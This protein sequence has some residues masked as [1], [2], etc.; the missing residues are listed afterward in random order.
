MLKLGVKFIAQ[1]VIVVQCALDALDGRQYDFVI[2]SLH[3]IANMPDFY[4]L[5]NQAFELILEIR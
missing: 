3:N 2:G 4:H 5:G 1:R